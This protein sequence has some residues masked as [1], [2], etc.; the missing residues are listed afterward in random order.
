MAVPLPRLVNEAVGGYHKDEGHCHCRKQ[1]AQSQP[2][3]ALDQPVS[4]PAAHQTRE[5]NQ[6]HHQAQTR[7]SVNH[8]HIHTHLASVPPMPSIKVITTAFIG[9]MISPADAPSTLVA[10]HTETAPHCVNT[11]RRS[12][13]NGTN[14]YSTCNLIH[15][16]ASCCD[17]PKVLCGCHLQATKEEVGGG[18]AACEPAAQCA[19]DRHEQGVH[20]RR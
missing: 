10:A 6:P 9:A 12:V 7:R 8:P 16:V 14:L 20:S 13:H 17:E 3:Q 5:H 19:N 11:A 1:P 4:P 2:Q 15:R 18:G